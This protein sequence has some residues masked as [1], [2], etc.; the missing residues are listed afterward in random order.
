IISNTGIGNINE[1]YKAFNDLKPRAEQS[2][3]KS[4]EA[5]T[6]SQNA[7]NVAN[8]IDAKATNALSLS[9][10]ADTLSK[11]VQEQF[12]QVVIDGDSSIEAAQA[13][14]DA[15]GQT[16]PTLKARLDKEHNEVT[17]QLA[18]TAEINDNLFTKSSTLYDGQYEGYRATVAY[19]ALSEDMLVVSWASSISHYHLKTEE[20]D[21]ISNQEYTLTFELEKVD[22]ISSLDSMCIYNE[23][24]VIAETIPDI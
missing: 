4:A 8:G 7:L 21:L 11:S 10:S 5:L 17:A 24:G 12:N 15:S 19:N 9:E 22:P 1:Y 6:K 3:T 2:I 16:N 18:Q 13:R 23:Q 20:I 14:V